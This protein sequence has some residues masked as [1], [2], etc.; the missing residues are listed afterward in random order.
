V[1]DRAIDARIR[2]DIDSELRAKGCC[3]AEGTKPDFLLNFRLASEAAEVVKANPGRYFYGAGWY[4]W[5]GVEALYTDRL[6]HRSV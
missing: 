2:A 1:L 4:G 3:P 6:V 5:A